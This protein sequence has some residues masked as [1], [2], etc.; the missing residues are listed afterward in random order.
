MCTGQIEL[1]YTYIIHHTYSKYIGQIQST[2]VKTD[3]PLKINEN[4]GQ[5][6][7]SW[8]FKTM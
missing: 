1:K 2:K 6:L 7:K 4:I 3:Q 5:F 8:V